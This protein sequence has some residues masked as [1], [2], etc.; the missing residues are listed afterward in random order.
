MFCGK[1]GNEIPEG[2]SFCVK[3]GAKTDGAAPVQQTAVAS[4]TVRITPASNKKNKN[5]IIAVAAIAAVIL[6]VVLFKS[7]SSP[8]SFKGNENNPD[9]LIKV[10]NNYLSS[11]EYKYDDDWVC[12]FEAINFVGK[13]GDYYQFDIVGTEYNEETGEEYEYTEDDNIAEVLTETKNGIKYVPLKK[14]KKTW[15]VTDSKYKSASSIV[16]AVYYDYETGN[17]KAGVRFRNL[18]KYDV[19]ITELTIKISDENSNEI[20]AE[21][22]FELNEQLSSN[23]YIDKTFNLGNDEF[24]DDLSSVTWNISVASKS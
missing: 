14:W 8:T 9:A 3:C 18:E 12:D 11:D 20:I 5:I 1:C 4:E 17:L 15:D 23:H 2:G 10:A 24:V 16:Y 6:I 19:K 7:L 22:T 13:L 21:R